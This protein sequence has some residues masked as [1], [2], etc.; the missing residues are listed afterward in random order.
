M[1]GG[2]CRSRPCIHAHDRAAGTAAWPYDASS[3]GPIHRLSGS[4]QFDPAPKHVSGNSGSP[5][6]SNSAV[7]PHS[8]A[9][10]ALCTANDETLSQSHGCSSRPDERDVSDRIRPPSTSLTSNLPEKPADSTVQ[11]GGSDL[12]ADLQ[13]TKCSFNEFLSGMSLCSPFRWQPETQC[14]NPL[15][16]RRFCAVRS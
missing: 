6:V 12:Q 3:A 8:A 2:R 5:V 14:W 15:R 9:P 11:C 4:P 7:H 16:C 1:N 10:R 13:Y